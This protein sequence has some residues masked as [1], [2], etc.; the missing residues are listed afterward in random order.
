MNFT[1]EATYEDESPDGTVLVSAMPKLKPKS[2]Q[3]MPAR[4]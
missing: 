1:Y 3:M 2:A 4:T